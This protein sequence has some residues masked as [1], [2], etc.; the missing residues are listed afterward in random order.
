MFMTG[1]RVRLSNG[2]SSSLFKTITEEQIGPVIL[3]I[4]ETRRVK[5]VSIR[6]REDGVYGLR[7]TDRYD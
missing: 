7:I 3:Q 1:I 2:R 4:D 6:S 5:S